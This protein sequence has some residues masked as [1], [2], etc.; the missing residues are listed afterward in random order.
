[1]SRCRVIYG[2][3]AHFSKPSPFS[4]CR[5]KLRYGVYPFLLPRPGEHSLPPCLSFSI[6]SITTVVIHGLPEQPLDDV[7]EGRL[8]I[9]WS[10]TV[11]LWSPCPFFK[12]IS[13]FAL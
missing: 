5:A 12:A 2:P 1:M 3:H 4:R 8:I 13:L 11:V 6:L 9:R 10:T 7:V